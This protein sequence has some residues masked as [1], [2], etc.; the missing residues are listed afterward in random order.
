MLG[1]L[2]RVTRACRKRLAALALAALVFLGTLPH[3]ACLCASDPRNAFCRSATSGREIARE[4]PAPRACC[5][6][7]RARRLQA[8]PE[9][10]GQVQQLAG[11][12]QPRVTAPSG[13]CCGKVWEPALPATAAEATKATKGG[14]WLPLTSFKSGVAVAPADRFGSN[15]GYS[16]RATPPP[17]DAVIVYLHLT[18]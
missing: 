9:A 14:D 4:N 1:K 11:Y 5:L 2:T 12:G 10:G 7:R 16:L 13:A 3:S 17:L 18:I 15:S 6:A 8:R